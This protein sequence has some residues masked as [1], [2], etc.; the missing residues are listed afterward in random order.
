MKQSSVREPAALVSW[1]VEIVLLAGL[2]WKHIGLY[3]SLG[4]WLLLVLTPL[5]AFAHWKLLTNARIDTSQRLTLFFLTG[6][7]LL[8]SVSLLA[9][10]TLELRTII[11]LG[12][13]PKEMI[14]V[15]TDVPPECLPQW[16]NDAIERMKSELL[17][18]A[19]LLASTCLLY[20]S[21]WATA[22]RDST[23]STRVHPSRRNRAIRLPLTSYLFEITIPGKKA[24]SN[25]L[26]IRSEPPGP[27]KE[28]ASAACRSPL[29]AVRCPLCGATTLSGE[30]NLLGQGPVRHWWTCIAQLAAR[31]RAF[32][33]L[34]QMVLSLTGRSSGSRWLPRPS[35]KKSSRSRRVFKS[36]RRRCQRPHSRHTLFGQRL[37]GPQ[38]LFNGTLPAKHRHS[39]G[40]CSTMRRQ[41]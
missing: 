22:R 8:L 1:S 11:F 38:R 2:L 40:W 5:L 15:I 26:E 24:M 28:A 30:W 21:R 14:S 32:G 31:G 18:Y 3:Y 12:G 19:M 6:P 25:E 20:S 37:I 36:T 13:P 41:A 35:R 39:W 16:T 29:S 23:M 34:S 9:A 27:W 33:S 4:S 7:S 10:T 17:I